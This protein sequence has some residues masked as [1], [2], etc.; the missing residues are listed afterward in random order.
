MQEED[1][2]H[3]SLVSLP[4]YINEQTEERT[5]H[6]IADVAEDCIEHRRSPVRHTIARRRQPSWYGRTVVECLEAQKV[7]RAFEV[8]VALKAARVVLV[9]EEHELGRGQ[10]VKDAH[11]HQQL[12]V[13][14]PPP[15]TPTASASGQIDRQMGEEKR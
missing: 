1:N 9:L 14:S 4:G 5:A 12:V 11:Q 8:V 2:V 6:N 13:L 3:F 15:G 10:R 7:V